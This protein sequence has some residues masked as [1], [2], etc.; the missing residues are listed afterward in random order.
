MSEESPRKRH[1]A[2]CNA[3]DLRFGPEESAAAGW[4]RLWR[5][6]ELKRFGLKNGIDR[7]DR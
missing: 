3:L 2:F 1:L 5:K 6:T 7:D 4:G